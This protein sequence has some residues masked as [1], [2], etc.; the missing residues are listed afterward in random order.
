M[1]VDAQAQPRDN[2]ILVWKFKTAERSGRTLFAITVQD[3]ST[4]LIENV[5]QGRTKSHRWE[6]SDLTELATY[7]A[8][9]GIEFLAFSHRAAKRVVFDQGMAEVIRDSAAAHL[10]A[11]ERL[12]RKSNNAPIPASEQQDMGVVEGTN[13]GRS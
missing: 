3:E 13:D 2:G 1:R 10:D 4:R 11:M 12:R 6:V 7:R 5:G 9:H 8:R